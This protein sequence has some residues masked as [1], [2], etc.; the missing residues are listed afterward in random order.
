MAR[1]PAKSY[2][3]YKLP[4]IEAL[5]LSVVRR[6][7]IGTPNSLIP[8][9]Y[10]T[11]T[12]TIN[13][14]LPLESEKA[15]SEHLIVPVLNDIRLRNPSA[16]TYF[17][18]YTFNVDETRGL[19]GVCDFIIS[20][21]TDAMYIQSPILAIVEAKNEEAI[22]EAIPQCAAEMF[23]ARLFNEQHGNQHQTM[24]G[25]ITSGYEWMF[26]QLVNSEVW[27]DTHRFFL[28]ALPEL[29]GALYTVLT[30]N[31]NNNQHGSS[32]PSANEQP[33]TKNEQP[34]T[35]DQATKQL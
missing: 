27:V 20:S 10:L 25:A 33:K 31:A 21:K 35:N 23:A 26:L 12:L 13:Q 19:K 4:D 11:M 28:N 18:G 15:K 16:F 17:S 34:K 3:A 9:E 1:K 14:Q 24:F 32:S 22:S 29:L 6:N 7:F 5:G 2:S 30:H 8:S